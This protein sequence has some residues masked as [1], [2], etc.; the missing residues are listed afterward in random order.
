M[1]CGLVSIDRFAWH[2]VRQG[3]RFCFQNAKTNRVHMFGFPNVAILISARFQRV[4]SQM[5]ENKFV[6][7]FIYLFIVFE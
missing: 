6:L 1:G 2:C 5:K 7:K 4:M 3:C